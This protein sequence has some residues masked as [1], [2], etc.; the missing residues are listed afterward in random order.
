MQSGRDAV[1]E[2]DLELEEELRQ[3]ED[4]TSLEEAVEEMEQ[5]T[6]AMGE[7]NSS[8]NGSSST[9]LRLDESLEMMEDNGV[10]F[11]EEEDIHGDESAEEGEEGGEGY[12][13]GDGDEPPAAG[14]RMW[15]RKSL[16]VMGVDLALFV[17]IAFSN[18]FIA[19]AITA[20]FSVL[21]GVNVFWSAF[22]T[23]NT[24]SACLTLV[25][26]PWVFACW[27]VKRWKARIRIPYLLL[28]FFLSYIFMF[29]ISAVSVGLLTGVTASLFILTVYIAGEDPS[30]A[31]AAL[32]WTTS[33]SFYVIIAIVWV[34]VTGL[35]TA[36]AI[37]FLLW[38][39]HAK[40]GEIRV[41][42]GCILH[43]ATSGLGIGCASV[44]FFVIVQIT[45]ML[46]LTVEEVGDFQEE[47]IY[48]GGMMGLKAALD[49]LVLVVTLAVYIMAGLWVSYGAA[50]NFFLE[51]ELSQRRSGSWSG[52]DEDE[53]RIIDGY[54]WWKVLLPATLLM[55]LFNLCVRGVGSFFYTWQW[56]TEEVR[57]VLLAQIC[58]YSL[59]AVVAVLALVYTLWKIKKTSSQQ[60]YYSQVL[61]SDEPE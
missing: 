59:G 22:V 6:I 24:A 18:F 54:P 52:S 16:T 25:L 46:V 55:V 3:A 49:L 45:V 21:R 15:S 8:R 35:C 42:L 34:V 13:Y 27:K 51:Q 60:G 48:K 61:A 2:E 58:I 19:V 50:I 4:C 53:Q 9:I 12:S 26:L 56:F 1:E 28:N 14:E 11:M 20:A 38:V 39:L 29:L 43:G 10:A 30:T 17:A 44:N 47:E 57:L 5:G 23:V 36:A 33:I 40:L 37:A 41:R 32:L 7:R 31:T